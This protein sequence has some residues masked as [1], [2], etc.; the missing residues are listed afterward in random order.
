MLSRAPS[1]TPKDTK[2]VLYGDDYF[3][4]SN[5][6]LLRRRLIELDNV[7][8][9]ALRRNT[10][11]SK[12]WYQQAREASVWDRNGFKETNFQRGAWSPLTFTRESRSGADSD[13]K[14]LVSHV[15]NQSHSSERG[16]RGLQQKQGFLTIVDD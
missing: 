8:V 12:E 1:V 9:T 6:P 10:S 11:F 5:T 15:N 16:G 3:G 7:L 13:V 4:N 2:K 14:P